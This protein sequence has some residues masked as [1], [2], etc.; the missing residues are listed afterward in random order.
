MASER[1]L[2]RL[3]AAAAG[4]GT[5]RADPPTPRVPDCGIVEF[6]TSP[7]F[8]GLKLFPLQAL[9]L[10]IAVLAVELLTSFDRV[11]LEEWG[12]GFTLADDGDA[13]A[14]RGR[15]GTTPDLM[16]RMEACRAAGRD[17]CEELV[18]VLGRRGSKSFLAAVLVVWR[19]WLLLAYGDPQEHFGIPSGKA[20]VV[21]LFA[22]D[23][24]TLLRN[25]YRDVTGLLDAPCF[26]PFRGKATTAA[27][28]LLTPAQ[29]RRG[30][31]P[32]RDEGLVQIVA[33]TTKHTSI[34]GSAVPTVWIDETG[35]VTGAGST[36]DS[37]ELLQAAEPALAQFRSDSLIVQTSTPY[38]MDGAFFA[39]YQK[40]LAVDPETGAALSPGTFLFQL[41]SDELYRFAG[42]AADLEMWPGGPCFDPDLEPVITRD[43]IE[44][45]QLWDPRGVEIEYEAQFAPHRSAYLLT[46]KV[47]Q[48]F[49]PYRGQHLTHLA[50]GKS[51]FTYV[52]HVDPG[53]TEA[54]YAAAIG[55]LEW[56]ADVPHVIVDRID[57][58]KPSDFPGGTIDYLQVEREL[59]DLIRAFRISTMR[60]D[61]WNSTSTIQGLRAKATE[62]ALGWR[63]DIDER[64]LSASLNWSS[65]EVFKKA[66]HL[67]LFHSPAHPLAQAELEHLIVQGTR[68]S[69]P[70][71]G[72]VQTDDVA[73]CLIGLTY[74]LLQGHFGV[75]NALSAVQL[76][77]SLQ[78]GLPTGPRAPTANPYAAQFSAVGRA[79]ADR[80]QD[81]YSNPARRIRRPR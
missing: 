25:G 8:L 48:A 66:V 18:L 6:A 59:L 61:H 40:A 29:L 73:D 79:A 14:F 72:P 7:E 81:G 77:G 4:R 55:H 30:G 16:D 10:K 52:A 39:S 75:F 3:R 12:S 64:P 33:A 15:R 42:Q 26:D 43:D 20:V 47:R 63:P 78:G 69:A 36:S 54:N 44:T 49:G 35:H 13:P 24:T 71:S 65:A 1:D 31:S 11:I 9:I 22:A 80:S 62:L 5:A 53:K 46:D 34:R 45:R 23:Q 74:T 17:V 56:A 2:V 58:W 37:I 70:A 19:L 32:G 76:F 21:H 50:A 38:G 67:G 68:V 41:P 57:V 51:N 27:V 60:F 28:T